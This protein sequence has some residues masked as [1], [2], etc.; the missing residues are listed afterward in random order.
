MPYALVAIAWSVAGCSDASQGREVVPRYM[1]AVDAYEG[2]VQ[3]RPEW[4]RPPPPL[5]PL[6]LS[7]ESRD[8][9][10]ALERSDEEA[11]RLA[12]QAGASPDA[13]GVD[14]RPALVVAAERGLPGAVRML[15]AAG[16]RP[17][18]LAPNGRSA[19]MSAALNGDE[20]TVQA[21][22]TRL[23]GDATI[24]WER[25]RGR[26][27]QYASQRG[28]TRVVRALLASGTS[29]D[30]RAP[31]AWHP[32]A[33][34]AAAFE[35]YLDIV[36]LLVE[37]GASKERRCEGLAAAAMGGQAPSL[38]YLYDSQAPLADWLLALVLAQSAWAGSVEATRFLLERGADPNAGG[39]AEQGYRSGPTHPD[40]HQRP[41]HEAVR[42]KY[43]PVVEV[44]LAYGARVTAED[45]SRAVAT[46]QTDAALLLLQHG[47][48]GYADRFGNEPLRSAS[49]LGDT[50]MV[51]LLLDAGAP[52]D[53]DSSGA[54]IALAAQRGHHDVARLLLQRGANPIAVFGRPS[55]DGRG[56]SALGS[57]VYNEDAEMLRLLV[58]GARAEGAS[59]AERVMDLTSAFA[60]ALQG[61]QGPTSET[62]FLLEAG[63]DPTMR[64]P[65]GGT[66]LTVLIRAATP[67]MVDY[68]LAL[69]VDPNVPSDLGW[70]PLY[71]AV[72]MEDSAMV[73]S[74]VRGGADPTPCIQGA[75]VSLLERAKRSGNSEVV[76]ALHEY[77]ADRAGWE[78]EGCPAD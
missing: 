78:E 31:D 36:T 34:A 26:A 55:G 74:L 22:V 64:P 38:Q 70:P 46:G 9:L 18:A 76:A 4:K 75:R 57:A 7:V 66:M 32:S 73:R 3:E 21:F 15:L 13:R 10:Q 60:I 68:L 51:R 42:M 65:L 45:L 39:I 48:K 35:G 58:A 17:H 71:E 33:L 12:L 2:T 53:G 54:P 69:G 27:L 40:R 24:L 29:P 50:A 67:E 43:A 49:A 63:A 1:L 5:F 52:V 20:R 61:S 23:S 59:E 30:A 14:G 62:E 72:Y 44:L 41:L 28:H 19:F 47:G 25:E 6:P 16:A 37:A 77:G 11:T 8:L 56:W